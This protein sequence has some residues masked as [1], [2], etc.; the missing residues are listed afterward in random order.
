[1]SLKRITKLF[2]IF[3]HVLLTYILIDTKKK[4]K[5]SKKFIV[6]FPIVSGNIYH[7]LLRFVSRRCNLNA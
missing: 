4:K 1:M 7:C 2:W 6:F 5:T 3:K